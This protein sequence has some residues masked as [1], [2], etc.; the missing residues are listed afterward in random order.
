VLN[1]YSELFSGQLRTVKGVERET[2]LVDQV[3]VQPPPYH[4]TPPE[5]KLLKEFVETCYRKE[6]SGLANPLMRSRRFYYL[7][8]EEGIGW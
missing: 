7:S 5:L 1:E 2:E 4:C 3:P 8:W 6:W